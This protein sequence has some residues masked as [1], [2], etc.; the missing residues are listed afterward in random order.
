M[1]T[2]TTRPWPWLILRAME[3]TRMA[4]RLARRAEVVTAVVAAI[5]VVIVLLARPVA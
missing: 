2:L 3:D 1:P 4:H 5:L